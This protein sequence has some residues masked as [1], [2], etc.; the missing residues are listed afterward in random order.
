M[1]LKTLA[2]GVAALLIAQSCALSVSA[3]SA[4]LKEWQR[5]EKIKAKVAK[6]SAEPH[7]KVIVTLDDDT[8]E[9]GYISSFEESRFA[10]TEAKS[11]LVTPLS[12]RA[13]KDVHKKNSTAKV[14]SIVA[15]SAGTG[16]GMLYLIAFGLSKCSRCID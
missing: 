9:E 2:A 1:Y 4:S 15:L 5:I 14:V 6:L 8:T 7:A 13:V 3:Q 11:G 10:L 16:V 12:Y